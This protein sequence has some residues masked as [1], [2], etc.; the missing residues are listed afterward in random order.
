MCVAIPGIVVDINENEN[1]AT[2]DFSGNR[3]KAR[4]GLVS[5]E[6]GDYALVHAGCVMQVM[7][8]D[9]AEELIELLNEVS[10]R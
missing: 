9:E 3:V 5:V 6:L 2:I 1:T 10:T 4:T 7:K 8:K